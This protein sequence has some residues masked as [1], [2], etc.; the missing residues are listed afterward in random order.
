MFYSRP[1]IEPLSWDLVAL[2]TPDGSRNHAATTC[3]GRPVDFRFS[4]GW[5]TVQR[6]EPGSSPDD[7]MEEILSL[8][9]S[10]FGITDIFP[11]QLCDIL[12]LTVQGERITAPLLA[13]ARGF[14]WSGQTT[15]WCS[16]HAMLTRDDAELLAEKI[17]CAI[18]DTIMLQPVWLWQPPRVKCRQIRFLMA[19]DKIVTFAIGWD[20]A[21]LRR[22]LEADA[23]PLQEFET[24]RNPRVDLWRDDHGQDLTGS[25]RLREKYAVAADLDYEVTQ[26]R[27]Y[28]LWVEYQTAD[29]RAQ[30]IMRTLAQV[31]DSH[32]GRGLEL[33]DL[34]T[35]AVIAEDWDDEE[36]TKSYSLPFKEWCAERKRRYFSVDTY[37]LPGSPEKRFVGSRPIMR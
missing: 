16:T 25:K 12:G 13:S 20:A 17:C 36:D 33:V 8:Q 2:P 5:L 26:H 24:V 4:S 18:P 28:R 37:Q 29:T 11:E 14:D 31:F 9:I 27:H 22:L 35:G 3:D 19:S 30:E 10:P 1:P 21:M 6:G 34:E 32:F 7:D 23:V 15:Y